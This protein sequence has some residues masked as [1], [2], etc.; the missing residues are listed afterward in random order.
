MLFTNKIIKSAHFHYIPILL[1]A[2]CSSINQSGAFN[3]N[4]NTILCKGI[5]PYQQV[6]DY[7]KHQH[8]KDI[9]FL[10]SNEQLSSW[11]VSQAKF[12]GEGRSHNL[13]SIQHANLFK[14]K[15]LK[16]PGH[17]KIL[18]LVGDKNI[19]QQRI[20]IRRDH[21]MKSHILNDQLDAQEGTIYEADVLH[22]NIEKTIEQ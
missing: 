3:N 9:T 12:E 10:P 16:L 6:G 18:H 14:G 19:I 11:D 17:V 2:I 5:T 1:L 21:F 22:I 15:A 7:I 8:F 20:D 4:L 13:S